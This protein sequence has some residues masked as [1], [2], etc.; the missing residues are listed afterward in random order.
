MSDWTRGY[1]DAIREQGEQRREAE[2][3]RKATFEAWRAR[4]DQQRPPIPFVLRV[5]RL[6]RAS[7][8]GECNITEFFDTLR[9][10]VKR[11]KRKRG[12]V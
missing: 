2:R 7:E 11:Q 8:T 6:L 12:G 9:D 4:M 1:I 5:D 10:W 3:E